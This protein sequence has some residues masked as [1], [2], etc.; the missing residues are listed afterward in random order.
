MA[1]GL[2]V[3]GHL[4]RLL[5]CRP[6]G[7]DFSEP[8]SRRERRQRRGPSRFAGQRRCG[9]SLRHVCGSTS[10]CGRGAPSPD[11]VVVE[12]VSRSLRSC[13]GRRGP[14]GRRRN[15][16]DRYFATSEPAMAVEPEVVSTGPVGP[17]AVRARPP[18]SVHGRMAGLFARHVVEEHPVCLV[19]RWRGFRPLVAGGDAERRRDRREVSAVVEGLDVARP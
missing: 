11:R 2:R 8:R 5:T 18:V 1:A 17:T 10:G 4:V 3:R 9:Y 16:G 14:P 6:L 15:D 12:A 13:V 7:R 19:G